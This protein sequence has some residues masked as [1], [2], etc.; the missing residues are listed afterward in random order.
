MQL[1]SL[2]ISE[3]ALGRLNKANFTIVKLEHLNIL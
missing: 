2:L 3:M 1:T